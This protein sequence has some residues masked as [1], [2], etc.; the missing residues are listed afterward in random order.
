MHMDLKAGVKKHSK[1]VKVSSWSLKSAKKK[2]IPFCA[3]TLA[4]NIGFLNIKAETYK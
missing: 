1:F 4:V 3:Y 2:N